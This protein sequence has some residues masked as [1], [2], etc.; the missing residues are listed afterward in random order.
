MFAFI[1]RCRYLWSGLIVV[2]GIY[3]NVYSKRSKLS[4][5]DIYDRLN[6]IFNNLHIRTRSKDK[7]FLL[8]V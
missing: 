3:L 8:D 4:F 7:N 6:S 5:T 2:L 1:F